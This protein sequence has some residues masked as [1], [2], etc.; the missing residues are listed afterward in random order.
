MNIEERSEDECVVGD[1]LK[2]AKRK[3][4]HSFVCPFAGC[5]SKFARKMRLTAHINAHTGDKPYLCDIDGCSQSF[6]AKHYLAKHKKRPHGPPPAKKPKKT[7]KCE[8]CAEEFRQRWFLREHMFKHTGEKPFNCDRCEMTFRSKSHL[9][10]H[11]KV[12]DGYACP[13]EDCDFETATWTE[14]RKHAVTHKLKHRCDECPK[15]YLSLEKLNEHRASHTKAYQCVQCGNAY[16]TKSNLK[17][18]IKADHEL[19]TFDCE[20]EGCGHKFT[21]KTSLKKHVQREHTIDEIAALPNVRR[22]Q[23][24]FAS[25]LTGMELD[26]DEQMQ[27]M[28][29]DKLFRMNSTISV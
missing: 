5:T 28:N 9:K 21:Y 19:T 16:T 13:E 25:E 26:K 23:K 15:V 8:I 29:A 17:S 11:S 3:P 6:T 22:R 2:G 18:H 7:F 4:R 10:R 12:H 20:V 24:A 27:I 1:G 14:L